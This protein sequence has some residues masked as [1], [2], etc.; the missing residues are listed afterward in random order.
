[1]CVEQMGKDNSEW[2]HLRTCLE[3]LFL[4]SASSPA[5]SVCP[6]SG[7]W[8]S[9]RTSLSQILSR[10]WIACR[11]TKC[12]FCCQ[13]QAECSSKLRNCLSGCPCRNG[14]SCFFLI[15]LQLPAEES[16]GG[17]N[18]RT[19]STPAFPHSWVIIHFQAG[20]TSKSS[21]WVGNF[22]YQVIS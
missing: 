15:S 3:H 19:T 21:R 4:P 9:D 10:T 2:F 5:W 17:G 1:M 16:F 11:V 22:P 6:I 14:C 13:I 12:C 18:P 7:S 8:R 20:S